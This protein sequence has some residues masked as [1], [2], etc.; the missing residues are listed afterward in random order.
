MID[1]NVATVT[2]SIE[3]TNYKDIINKYNKKGWH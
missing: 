1:G 3:V 2:T